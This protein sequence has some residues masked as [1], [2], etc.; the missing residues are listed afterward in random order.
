MLSLA[1]LA[2]AFAATALGAVPVPPDRIAAM[3]LGAPGDPAEA[4]II[5][6]IRLPRVVAA[7]LV[8]G[9]LAAAGVVFQGLLRNPMADPYIIGT[10]GGAAL[11]VTVALL[12]PAGLVP[13][14][15]SVTSLFAFGG[16][17]AAVLIVYNIARVGRRT[18]ITT[19]LLAGF[20]VSS[21]L[22]AVMSFLMLVGGNTLRQVI[23][24]TMGGLAVTGWSSVLGV[25]PLILLGL[26]ATIPFARDLNLLLLGEEQ[27]TTMG[28]SVERRKLLLLALG[29]F[30]TAVAVSLSGLVGFV[31]LVVP[32]I[33]R[34]VLGPDHRLLL[35]A[36]T[37]AGAIFLVLADLL[38]R[39]FIAPAEMPVGI[40]TALVGAPF[41]IYLL[42]RN[43][44][45]YDF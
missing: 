7:I 41:F 6:Q 38:A 16:A 29:S 37:L 34:L 11:G 4:T 13:A 30:L 26:A 2:G 24:W 44:R 36:A 32:H 23:L 20:A 21:M 22:A 28:L 19:L 43:R 40:I 42:R 3:V 1:L 9:A 27:A 10:S 31:G 33:V 8:G 5:W 12:I 25:A 45:D 17:L 39:T 14:G 15:L 35:P 18:P